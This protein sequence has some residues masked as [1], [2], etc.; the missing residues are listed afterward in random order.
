VVEFSPL[1]FV[2]NRGIQGTDVDDDDVL[3]ADE[4]KGGGPKGGEKNEEFVAHF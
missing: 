3:N 4:V 1:S 2:L